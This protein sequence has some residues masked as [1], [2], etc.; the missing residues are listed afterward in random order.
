MTSSK[1]DYEN[2]VERMIDDKIKYQVYPGLRTLHGVFE[3]TLA[4]ML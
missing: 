4:S 1:L 2:V 3:D